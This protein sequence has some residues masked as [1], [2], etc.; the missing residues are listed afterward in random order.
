MPALDPPDARGAGEHLDQVVDL[1]ALEHG[2]LALAGGVRRAG[3]DVLAELLERHLHAV[4]VAHAG[5]D[6]A[7]SPAFPAVSIT[8]DAGTETGAWTRSYP[9][10]CSGLMTSAVR[11]PYTTA[12][13]SSDGIDALIH[14]NAVAL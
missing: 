9:P 3:D 5:Q 8:A 6:V 2:D 13:E 1:V 4:A 10:L 11:T 14:L 12:A 7:H